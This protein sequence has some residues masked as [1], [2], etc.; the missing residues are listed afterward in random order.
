[1]A[2]RRS[3]TRFE[4][5]KV[6][7]DWWGTIQPPD[8]SRFNSGT[9]Y[10]DIGTVANP[11]R[12]L[13]AENIVATDI[14]GTNINVSVTQNISG[15]TTATG[16]DR[17]VNVSGDTMTGALNISG[18]SDDNNAILLWGNLRIGSTNTGIGRIV[19]EKDQAKNTNIFRSYRE[20][21]NAGTI[22]M[23]FDGARGTQASPAKQEQGDEIAKIW[24]RGHDSN[25]WQEAA[26]I[27]FEVDGPTAAGAMPGRITLETTPVS[28]TTPVERLRVNSS[29][30][31]GIGIDIGYTERVSVQGG[32][33]ALDNTYE[34]QVGNVGDT[35][36]GSLG[37]DSD[38]LF[39]LASGNKDLKLGSN[40]RPSGIYIE[41]DTGH[42]GIGTDNPN[43]PLHVVSDADNS[44]GGIRVAASD[45]AVNGGYLILNKDAGLGSR[46]SIQAGDSS[47][48]RG[49][50]LNPTGGNVGINVSNPSESLHVA[51]DHVRLAIAGAT[52]GYVLT[53]IDSNG[54]A[55]WASSPNLAVPTSG[56]W[57]FSGLIDVANAGWTSGLSARYDGLTW[58]PID[59]DKR[60]QLS[61]T[62]GVATSGQWSLSGLID[63]QDTGWTSGKIVKYDGTEF[64]PADDQG[65]TP[66]L[67][68]TRRFVELRDVLYDETFSAATSG[69]LISSGLNNYNRVEIISVVR[70]DS[71]GT[72]GALMIR[73]NGDQNTANYDRV[74]HLR[75]ETG[76][77]P[78]YDQAYRGQSQEIGPISA[79]GGSHPS[80]VSQYRTVIFNPAGSGFTHMHSIGNWR[81][82]SLEQE[83]IFWNSNIAWLDETQLS[84]VFVYSSG[85]D[86][87]K[88]GSRI[89]VVGITSG[90]VVTDV[91][92]A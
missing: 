67:N 79:D 68:T 23:V 40:I 48:V 58:Q 54:V 7:A 12:Y 5:F 89:T 46:A 63:T 21:P 66:T 39:L 32:N 72:D 81:R 44:D 30:N 13:Y 92:I 70:S 1:M 4:Y 15:I 74:A 80:E 29:G 43:R 57:T 55:V 6:N 27:K 20:A 52:S 41:G 50:E 3:N 33:I 28:S 61:G 10:L 18:V 88:A 35:H 16:D 86:N 83:H 19:V 51:G 75:R 14:S 34:Y 69:I 73:I 84:G 77:S 53:C 76:V 25:D 78:T 2:D 65:T 87:F 45:Y 42:V 36:V 64:V 47:S 71:A 22:N 85:S 59:L 38:V 31:V 37:N 17:Y 82:G 9:P 24:G 90:Y 91:S 60:Y 62:G 11:V 56:Q 26:N 8:A 49:L